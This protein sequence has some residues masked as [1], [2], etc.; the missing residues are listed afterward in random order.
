MPVSV[1]EIKFYRSELNS[2]VAA[3]NGAGISSVDVIDGTVN[4]LFPNTS[5]AERVAGITRYRKMFL[6]NENPDD[7]TL[8]SGE[9]FI[10]TQSLADDY[11]RIKVGTNDDVQSDAEGYSDWAGTGILSASAGSGETSIDVDYDVTNGV[12]DGSSVRITDGTNTINRI[13]NGTP[14]W[15][16]NTA[17]IVLTESLGVNFSQTSTIVS[18]VVDLGTVE[19]SSDSWS[20]SS[21]TGSY[22]ETT[23]PLTTYNIGTVVDSWT[24]T[25][26]D[27]SNFSIE[28]L[29]TGPMGSGDT[30]TDCMPVNGASYYF[31]IDKDGWG[32]AWAL[33][34]TIT[35]NTVHAGASIWVKEVVPSEIGS[36]SNNITRIGWRGE[37]G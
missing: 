34:D 28:G 35:F 23:Y 24:L 13:V 7:L 27:A 11:C 10:D 30:S 15:G 18:T 29:S 12:Y 1:D 36:Y 22:D 5:S 20:E 3:S 17:T 9:V 19:K 31:K 8:V 33:G 37:S 25:F 6:R 2:D 32:G 4:N 14:S 16:G 26:A 21:G